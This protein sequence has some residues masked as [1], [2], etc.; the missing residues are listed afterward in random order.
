[1]NMTGDHIATFRDTVPCECILWTYTTT[2][3]GE[4]VL[5]SYITYTYLN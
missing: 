2:I 3:Q 4:P 5:I 1:M